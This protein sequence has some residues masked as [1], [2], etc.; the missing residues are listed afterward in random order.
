[1][2]LTHKR[3]QPI[4]EIHTDGVKITFTRAIPKS[5]VNGT[6]SVED[7]DEPDHL[8]ED[9]DLDPAIDFNIA[10][11]GWYN[12]A[13]VDFSTTAN[14]SVVGVDPGQ[15]NPFT[16]F[17]EGCTREHHLQVHQILKNKHK[18]RYVL[19]PFG[20]TT[21][22]YHDQIGTFKYAKALR[23]LK[24]SYA[25]R[26]DHEGEIDWPVPAAT[27][28]TMSFKASTSQLVLAALGV[29]ANLQLHLYDIHCSKKLARI[30][31][32]NASRKR[33]FFKR[34]E[35]SLRW[36]FPNN[37]IIAFGAAKIAP[38][39]FKGSPA[40]PVSSTKQAFARV[41]RCIATPEHFT[42]QK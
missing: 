25:R 29:E 17:E 20:L 21:K 36:R 12:H 11:A 23:D 6:F 41:F 13:K 10:S 14:F 34:L 35:D 33:V 30:K 4:V 7:D 39:R 18:E 26:H 5:K 9:I 27:L 40:A 1:M 37:P 32:L 16:F 31:L 2:L 19:Q 15:N 42:S 38:A 3:G 24:L 8:E 28:A 22:A